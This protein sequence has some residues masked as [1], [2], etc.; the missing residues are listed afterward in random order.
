MLSFLLIIG[1]LLSKVNNL[2]SFLKIF[3][4]LYKT[5]SLF[6]LNLSKINNHL[7]QNNKK[8]SKDGFFAR[9]HNHFFV[10]F[11]YSVGVQ[12]LR[13]LNTR[14]KYRGSLNPTEPAISA[15]DNSG[16]C[17]KLQASLMR[18]VCR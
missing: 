1:L 12:P 2:K 11:W 14:E 4:R 17:S 9:L 8:P 13:D 15:M 18:Y 16:L 7:L 6:L 3:D 5:N 10:L